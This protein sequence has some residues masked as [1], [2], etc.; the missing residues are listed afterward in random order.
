M[1]RFST[2]AG[3][4]S[5]AVFSA[6]ALGAGP[7]T[8]QKISAYDQP[9]EIPPSS[10][11]GRQ[12]VDSR[13]CVYIRV[14]TDAAVTW[15]PRVS[16]KR[17]VLCGLQPTRTA[18]AQVPVIPDPVVTPPAP[19]R[20]AS[21]VPAR[22]MA[23]PVAPRTVIRTAA[24]PRAPAPRIQPYQIPLTGNAT[25]IRGG[26][27]HAHVAPGTYGTLPRFET[28]AATGRYA[29]GTPLSAPPIPPVVTPKGYVEAWDDGRL[30][31]H[32][33][34]QLLSGALQTALIWTQTVPR[35]LVDR[36]TGK[37]VTRDYNYLIYPYT[38]YGRQ[39][40]DLAGGQHV[41]V[42]V[43]GQRMIVAKSRLQ[44]TR[45]GH[46][47][48]S[49]KSAPRKAAAPRV[50]TAVRT[51]APAPQ[52]VPGKRYVQAGTF[53]D[54]ANAGR[55]VARL[56]NAGLPVRTQTIQRGGRQLQIVLAGPFADARQT[57]DGLAA[58][59]R[60]GFHDAFARN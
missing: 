38:D 34:K 18:A 49:T 40:R 58:V 32:R 28:A 16:R 47:T 52:A 33:G 30:N 60:A 26:A 46:V 12:Y 15:V 41:T 19:V 37:D 48:L 22:P 42:Q 45:S 14:G 10:F 55:T 17:E 44:E 13:G 4:L 11:R 24:A 29:V 59:R 51:A 7:V 8:A 6:A 39:K 43:N 53:G 31:P 21:S 57:Q 27:G 50:Q 1:K 20:T 35:R 2:V 5:A 54:A 56:Q 25:L 3:L 9:A 36:S 23:T